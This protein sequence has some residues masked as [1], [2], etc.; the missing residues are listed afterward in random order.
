[1]NAG[2]TTW[3]DYADIFGSAEPSLIARV[4][5]GGTNWYTWTRRD[6]WNRPTNIVETY[7]VKAGDTALTRT[8]V[9]VYSGSDLDPTSSSTLAQTERSLLATLMMA[10]I[11]SFGNGTWKR[12]PPGSCTRVEEDCDGMTCGGGFY[13]V[14]N[15][16]VDRCETP[17]KDSPCMAKRRWTPTSSG[18]NAEP[19]VWDPSI[20]RGRGSN[21]GNTPPGYTYYD[22]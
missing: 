15:F 14:N 3:F 21:Q 17:G 7:S 12:I 9:F 5:P 6:E 20:G 22:L 2:Q 19:P 1:V 4:L 18:I 11:R 8:N 10:A 13:Y 16:E